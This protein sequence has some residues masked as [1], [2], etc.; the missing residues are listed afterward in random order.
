[1]VI[2][3]QAGAPRTSHGQI[4]KGHSVRCMHISRDL[5]ENAKEIC[6]RLG[7]CLPPETDGN[8]KL[9]ANGL[10]H[11][12]EAHLIDTKSNLEHLVNI[13]DAITSELPMLDSP[14]SPMQDL[15]ERAVR[16]P[17]GAI[18]GGAMVGREP[19]GYQK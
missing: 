12:L 11:D 7:I 10:F 13:L 16:A 18:L 2:A 17:G 5:V 14:P 19:G 15:R 4:I 9:S 6:R 1:M 3:N 8:N